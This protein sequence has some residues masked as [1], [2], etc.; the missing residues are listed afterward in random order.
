MN[1]RIIVATLGQRES[2]KNTLKSI[3]N[4]NLD[5]LEVKMVVPV[6]KIQEIDSLAKEV[7][8]KDYEII[9][10]ENKGLSAAINQGFDAKGDFDFFC[11]INDDDELTG[12]SLYRSLKLIQSDLNVLAV[13]GN[14]GYV[15]NKK[16]KVITNRVSKLNLFVTKMG[17]NIIPQ[18]GSLIRRTAINNQT[19]LNDN[20]KYAMDLDLWLRILKEGKIGI[21][22]ETQ[23]LM[24]WHDDSI[25]VSNRKNA[26]IEAFN[27]RYKNSGNLFIKL[28]VVLFYFPTRFLSSLLSKIS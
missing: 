24:N 6:S 2:L 23:A 5:G 14:L 10:D 15:L 4:Q 9:Q 12:G 22:R 28:L 26:S 19:L 1:V 21:V 18:P 17:P 25:T 27:I 16:E 3:S 13:V 7:D 8:L 11:W 20:Y